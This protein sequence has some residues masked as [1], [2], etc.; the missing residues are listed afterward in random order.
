MDLPWKKKKKK[1]AIAYTDKKERE[2]KKKKAER[3]CRYFLL[4]WNNYTGRSLILLYSNAPNCPPNKDPVIRLTSPFK[5]C[6][7]GIQLYLQAT[8]PK[9]IRDRCKK[10]ILNSTRHDGP[11]VTC[12]DK[13]M[14][15]IP[16]RVCK[17]G[18]GACID[19]KLFGRPSGAED[20]WCFSLKKSV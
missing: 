9:R 5:M 7:S 2:K 6:S 19:R 1:H 12:T 3:K 8:R 20:S 14:R 18:F 4:N 17:A 13:Y 10:T 16:E 11:Q 15:T